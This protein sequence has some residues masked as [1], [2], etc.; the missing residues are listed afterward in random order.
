MKKK[1]AQ[2]FPVCLEFFFFFFFSSPISKD[3][4]L[5]GEMIVMQIDF[6]WEEAR[7]LIVTYSFFSY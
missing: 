1:A 3:I 5:F 6:F 7:E 2:S 4:L